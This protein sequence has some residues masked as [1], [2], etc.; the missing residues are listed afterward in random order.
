ME[1][2]SLGGGKRS[3]AEAF[4]RKLDSYMSD[5]LWF[6][7]L[8]GA[9]N[10]THWLYKGLEPISLNSCFV[11]CILSRLEWLFI[12]LW[13]GVQ[14]WMQNSW[15]I[16]QLSNHDIIV[17]GTIHQGGSLPLLGSPLGNPPNPENAP[18]Q[19]TKHISHSLLLNTIYI[20]FCPT[21]RLF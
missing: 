5:V 2:M 20:Q 4:K 3:N 8:C 13:K 18:L 6:G 1:S 15:V 16:V 19:Y 14:I 17:G 10:W 9:G 12:H 21:H 11:F 7:F